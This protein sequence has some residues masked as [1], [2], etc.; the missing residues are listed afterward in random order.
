MKKVNFSNISI[1]NFLSVG[2]EELCLV[3]NTGTNLITGVNKDIGGRNGVGKS[4]VIE[5]IYWAL[6]GS[7]IRDIKKDGILH[8]QNKNGCVV[9][10]DFSVQIGEAKNSYKLTRSIEPN[11]ISIFK[12]GEDV[13]LSTMP[14]NDEF[15]RD[16]IGANEE[17]FQNAVIMTANNT[18]PFMAQKKID[19][20]K[21]VEGIL[22]LG[23]FSEMLLRTRSDYT[24]NKKQNDVFSAKFTTQQRNLSIYEDQ[25]IKNKKIRDDKIFTLEQKIE[26]NLYNIKKISE[27]T[28][29]VGKIEENQKSISTCKENIIKL[30]EGLTK[31]EEIIIEKQ[32]KC[33]SSESEVKRVKS[34]I[35]EFK[36]IEDVCPTCN[37]KY[38]SNHTPKE[39]SI[40]ELEESLEEVS[41]K[42]EEYSIDLSHTMTKKG[43]IKAALVAIKREI[44]TYKSQIQQWTLDSQ[45]VGNLQKRNE[46]LSEEIVGVKNEKDTISDLMEILKKEI[47]V[48]SNS[49]S[50]LQKKLLILETAKFVVSEEGVK[51][52]IVKKMLTV[53]N[54]QL[55]FYLKTLDAPCTCQFDEVFEETI[56]NEQGKECSYFNFSGGERKR[57]DIAILFMFQDILR[58]QT[59]VAFNLSMYDELFDS[60]LDE[61]GIN[62]IL[63]ILK[64]RI[65]KYDESI[66]II[67]H[68]KSAANANFTNVIQLQKES[69]KT[70]IVY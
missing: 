30:E 28:S 5:S 15:I 66:Y 55:N 13:T 62:K 35:A 16:L 67:S 25:I 3:F 4:S 57:I 12:D 14:K 19:K 31:I 24:E 36:K 63:E 33:W 39:N 26:D 40:K 65:E 1:K 8:N 44:E 60:A 45:A 47:E 59:G 2:N 53:F 20:R 42:S 70:S 56:Y 54:S 58:M 64:E 46:E 18:M 69:G 37:R 52:F 49:I 21:F 10:L 38:D 6:F 29:I 41:K 11:K 27:D 50:D 68:N 43:D 9:V 34:E 7:T 61:K 51:S 17:V 22:N 23:I 48:I 32:Q